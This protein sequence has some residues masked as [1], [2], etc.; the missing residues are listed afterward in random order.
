MGSEM[1]IRDRA[2]MLAKSG[3]PVSLP[4]SSMSETYRPEDLAE[5]LASWDLA[6]WILHRDDNQLRLG[7]SDA[8][9]EVDLSQAEVRVFPLDMTV[10][11][12]GTTTSEAV[13][14]VMGLLEGASRTSDVDE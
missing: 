10:P 6:E 14:W 3:G 11:L 13:S 4:F 9:V 5:R 7:N 2:W 1:C 12:R 8:R